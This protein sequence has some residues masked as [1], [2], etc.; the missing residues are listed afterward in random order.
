MDFDTFFLPYLAS[1]WK[2]GKGG[3]GMHFAGWL[4][5]G[6][7]VVLFAFECVMIYRENSPWYRGRKK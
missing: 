2:N 1:T 5:I 3:D 4:A 6:M 7:L